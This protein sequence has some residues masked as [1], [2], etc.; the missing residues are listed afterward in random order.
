MNDQRRASGSSSFT[1]EHLGPAIASSGAD[2]VVASDRDG[3]IQFWNPG[4]ERIFGYGAAEV[5]GQ[6]LDLIIPERLRARHWEGFHAVMASGKSRYAAG[7]LL[8]VPAL[9]KNGTTISVEFTI[10]PLHSAAD[11]IIGLIA[12]MRD[13]TA[14]FEETKALRQKLRALAERS[15]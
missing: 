12:V 3:I 11:E 4:A 8:G 15:Q 9:R 7:D 1:A 14:K 10:T 6:S 5:L 2:A 13:V